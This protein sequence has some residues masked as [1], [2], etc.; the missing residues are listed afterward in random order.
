MQLIKIGKDYHRADNIT[1]IR[2][3]SFRDERQLIIRFRDEESEF[4]A[5]EPNDKTADRIVEL[6]IETINSGAAIIDM[7][8]IERQ[9]RKEMWGY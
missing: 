5:A 6:I 4:V 7:Q 9:V 1:L 2:F 3:N 8:Q